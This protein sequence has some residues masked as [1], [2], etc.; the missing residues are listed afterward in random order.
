[1][2]YFEIRYDQASEPMR[3]VMREPI[4]N[5]LSAFTADPHFRH[6]IGQQRS[7]FSIVEAMDQ[8]RWIIL[9]L[10]K[11]R[12][13]EQAATLGSLFLAKIKNALFSRQRR[14]IFSIFADEIQNLVSLGNGLETML[15]EARKFGVGI[16]TA[17]QFL[18]QFTP[19]MRA[20]LM[21]VGTHIFFQLSSQDA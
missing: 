10:H 17:N 11:G 4:L 13:G 14:N 8:G 6:I 9:N 5:K 12:L 21:A 19:E 1:K 3:A 18:E 20:A 15:S 2:R 7:T 16:V